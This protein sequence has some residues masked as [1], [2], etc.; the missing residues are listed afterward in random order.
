MWSSSGSILPPHP[1]SK[2][3]PSHRPTD[4]DISHLYQ[5][6]HSFSHYVVKCNNHI[7]Y[8]S[9]FFHHRITLANQLRHCLLH[10]LPDGLEGKH[11]REQILQDV[12]N[13]RKKQQ[14]KYCR[15]LKLRISN[16]WSH[17]LQLDI[18]MWH[19]HSFKSWGRA[20]L[21]LQLNTG[22]DDTAR[23]PFF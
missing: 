3:E 2:A 13:S 4:T 17:L 12:N 14:Q 18:C 5:Q 9:W 21:T 20:Q 23:Q 19:L 22:W 10:M 16:I 7:Y 11:Q 8:V 6:S 15:N 1:I